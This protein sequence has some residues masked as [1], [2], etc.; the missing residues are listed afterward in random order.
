MI[1]VVIT[2]L[3][4]FLLQAGYLLWKIS[5]DSL[6]KIGTEKLLVVIKGFLCSPK[7]LVGYFSTFIGW[8]LLV[9]AMDIGEISIVQPLVSV[10]DVFLVTMAVVFFEGEITYL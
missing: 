1:V 9:K 7:W 8:I 6:P 4:T 3:A 2:V 5:A 10:G